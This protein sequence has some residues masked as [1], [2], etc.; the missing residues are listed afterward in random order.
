M[1]EAAP[2]ITPRRRASGGKARHSWRNPRHSAGNTSSVPARTPTASNTNPTTSRAFTLLVYPLHAITPRSRRTLQRISG[3]RPLPQQLQVLHRLLVAEVGAHA[4]HL[5]AADRGYQ[6]VRG[7]L[8]ALDEDRA[9]QRDAPVVERPDAHELH[10]V[11]DVARDHVVQPAAHPLV[12]L[13]VPADRRDLERV[14]VDLGVRV[15]VQLLGVA[16]VHG[17]RP[18]PDEAMNRVRLVVGR[19]GRQAASSTIAI[20]CPTPMHIVARPWRAPRRRIS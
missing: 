11:A 5:V 13:V 9:E 16:L 14:D 18:A 8:L 7:D 17:R 19:A 15:G 1:A 6:G 10:V 3:I 2:P 20:P 4:D 12:P